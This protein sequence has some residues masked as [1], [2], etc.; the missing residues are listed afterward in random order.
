MLTL[1]TVK[2]WLGITGDPQDAELVLLEQQAVAVLEFG[3]K[4]HWPMPAVQLVE[5]HSLPASDGGL[6]ARS[7]ISCKIYLANAGELDLVEAREGWNSW[8]DITSEALLTGITL[9]L[10]ATYA[11]CEI[12]VT[13]TYGYADEGALPLNVRA[14]LLALA[15]WL[16]D[17]RA[18]GAVQAHWAPGGI[19]TEFY[20]QL[21]ADLRAM[22]EGLAAAPGIA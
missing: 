7:P 10:S 16:W 14:V 2:T 13:Y 4:R 11:G 6:M 12:R 9:E 20:E 21:P 17:R 18:G 1:A 19:K 8:R 3:A 15:R 5:R 22:V